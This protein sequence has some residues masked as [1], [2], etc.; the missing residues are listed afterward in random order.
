LPRAV[1][2]ASLSRINVDVAAEKLTFLASII[3]GNLSELPLRPDEEELKIV[4]QFLQSVNF[5]L[6]LP[7][8]VPEIQLGASKQPPAYTE[9]EIKFT[10]QQACV[11]IYAGS[12]VTYDGYDIHLE[13]LHSY[14]K[15]F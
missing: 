1:V 14:Q 8:E 4:L 10:L 9:A 3:A 15:F 12:G 2:T 5:R 7:E 6:L 13:P 11:T